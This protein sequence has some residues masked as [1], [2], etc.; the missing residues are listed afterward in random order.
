MKII[1]VAFLVLS[2]ANLAA[3][4]DYSAFTATVKLL[5]DYA[6]IQD[7]TVRKEKL[8]G[9]W[10]ALQKDQRI[11][12]V[13]GDS[14]AFFY[15][16]KA[17]S[18]DWMGDF[19]AWGYNKEFK[20]KGKYITGTGIW[21]LRASFPKDA[22]LDYKIMLDGR[23]WI[24][25]PENAVQQWSGVG[26]GSPNSELCMP[27]WKEDPYLIAREN[28]PHGKLETDILFSSKIL[29]YQITYGVYLPAEFDKNTKLQS[30]YVTDGYEYM[31][32]KLGNMVTVLDNL[33]ADKKI[34]PIVV[35][36]VDQREPA[37]RSNNKRMEELAMN[38]KYLDFFTN[39]FI[40]YIE[41]HYP[42]DTQ[43]FNRAIMGSSMG[44]LNAA[45]F[46]FSKPGVFG[47]AGIQS[48]AFNIRPQIYT[49]CNNP[50]QPIKVSMTSGLISDASEG[51]RKMKGILESNS[52]AYHYHEVNDGHSWGN[53]RNLIDDV[54]VD[55]FAY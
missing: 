22:R 30:L 8:D 14:V 34:R 24:L 5:E 39:E 47:M 46:A 29:G 44:G 13:V 9:W 23:S 48:P 40:P 53:W 4:Q 31:H 43:P 51:S 45:F 52:C 33:L 21:L 18:V 15:R 26:G 55:L 25:D 28:I 35:I 50:E 3:S 2:C 38:P 41:S 7:T 32:P 54:L 11:P 19:N 12:L 36:F 20:N 49:F 16:G 6:S 1:A 42:V 27:D 17:K 37:N 10:S